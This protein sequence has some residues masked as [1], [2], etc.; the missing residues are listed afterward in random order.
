MPLCHVCCDSGRVK[1]QHTGF[2][3]AFFVKCEKCPPPV[4]PCPDPGDADPS[5]YS[6]IVA[7]LTDRH[8]RG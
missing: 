2:T 5:V 8:W 4:Q 3:P 1:R 7:F 6:D